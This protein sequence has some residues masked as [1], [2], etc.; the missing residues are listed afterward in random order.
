MGRPSKLNETT[1]NAIL[2]AISLGSTYYLA[3]QSA[4]VTFK[5]FDNWM[6]RGGS[7]HERRAK[8][9]IRE[10][11]KQWNDE[12]SY[13]HFYTAVKE[14]EGQAV[15][16]WLAQIEAAARNGSWQAAAWKLERRYPQD[17]GRKVQEIQGKDG[18]PV[19]V[20]VQYDDYNPKT[21]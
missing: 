11:T 12:D 10:G 19:F 7:E 21:S 9:G 8:N 2:K 18:G 14:V 3:A 13:Y 17:Y 20:Q 4:G 16:T 6:K 15:S 1:Q 5:T